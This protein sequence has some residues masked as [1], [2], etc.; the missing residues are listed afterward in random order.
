MADHDSF[1]CADC[2]R[3]IYSFPAREPPP[4]IC[5]GCDWLHEFIDNPKTRDL[6]RRRMMMDE[7]PCDL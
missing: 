6:L 2:G 3:Q 5:A 4:T 1:V 7:G